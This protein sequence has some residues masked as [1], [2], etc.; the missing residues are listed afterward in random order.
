MK[1]VWKGAAAA[2][3]ALSLGATGFIGATSAYAVEGDNPGV[4][5]TTPATYSITIKNADEGHTFNAYQIFQGKLSEN[6]ATLS[7]VQ[8][9][10]GVTEAGQTAAYEYFELTGDNQTAA[11]VAEELAK[12]TTDSD[13]AKGFAALFKTAANLNAV[14]GTANTRNE[15]GN[16]VIDGLT[17]GYYLVKDTGIDDGD[18]HANTVFIMKVVGNA[19]ANVKS[20][21]PTVSKE[22]KD[23]AADKDGASTDNDGWG[24]SADHE[25]GETFQFKLTASLPADSYRNDYATYKLVFNDTMSKGITYK[26]IQSVKVNTTTVN[27]FAEGTNPNGYKVAGV[28]DGDKGAKTWTLTIDDIKTILTDKAAINGAITVEV[29]YNAQLNDDAVSMDAAGSIAQNNVVDLDY[30]N[31]PYGDGYGTTEEDKVYV[32][33]L[34]VNVNKVDGATQGALSGVKF[35]LHKGASDSA[36]VKVVATDDGYRLATEADEAEGS[37]TTPTTELVTNKDGKLNL[38]GLDTG[39]YYLVETEAL[40][41]YNKLDGPVKIE[42]A[43]EHTNDRVTSLNTAGKPVVIENNKGSNLPETGGMGTTMLYVA[44]GAIVLIAGIGMAVA[45]RR[46][47]A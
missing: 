5:E 27:A 8:W 44:G 24:D 34:K 16:Y 29:I 23:E 7:D 11:K 10:N 45:L 46:R 42:V 40:D 26:G 36:A 15:Q 4:V 33:T 37:T 20:S 1:K 41:G 43:A 47:R 39:T 31:N 28:Q 35:T 38:S 18:N 19:Q 3:A 6:G 13:K 21:K 9:G 14:A 22:V 2:I 17:A 12:A 25:I 30:S 32:A